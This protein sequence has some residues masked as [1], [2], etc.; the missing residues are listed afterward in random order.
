MPVYRFLHTHLPRKVHFPLARR[1][2]E[3]K[4][5]DLACTFGL[6]LI[7]VYQRIPLRLDL[8]SM[9]VRPPPVWPKRVAGRRNGEIAGL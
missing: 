9:R 8:F 2:F 7:R 1:I 6:E 4:I 5:L 3:I